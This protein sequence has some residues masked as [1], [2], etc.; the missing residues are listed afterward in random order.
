MSATV[1][2]PTAPQLGPPDTT[3][4]PR[5]TGLVR[6]ATGVPPLAAS[7]RCDAR[8]HGGVA[9]PRTAPVREDRAQVPREPA[10]LGLRQRGGRAHSRRP[11]AFYR[12]PA[13]AGWAAGSPPP[14]S[15][16]SIPPISR[17]PS[18]PGRRPH[19][20]PRPR[21]CA[22]PC[23]RL[24]SP[25]PCAW[26]AADL[27]I[28]AA[29][30]GRP[31]GRPSG[32]SSD[33][34]ARGAGRLPLV[35]ESPPGV[36]GPSGGGPHLGGVRPGGLER[37]DRPGAVLGV[38]RRVHVPEFRPRRRCRTSGGARRPWTRRSPRPASRRQ[39]VRPVR[40][41]APRTRAPRR[42]PP[43]RRRPAGA[44][45]PPRRPRHRPRRPSPHRR[46]VRRAP[47]GARLPSSSARFRATMS[48]ASPWPSASRPSATERRIPGSASSN[49]R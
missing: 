18:M 25:G 12:G 39:P 16:P 32:G 48:A 22:C 42:W 13:P 34:P 38:E 3:A 35:E 29:P 7:P 14:P 6:R 47:G 36:G 11:R 37:V 49:W 26:P 2:T 40:P 28:P 17:W 15:P 31:D 43:V 46:S 30:P 23:R 10:V 5:R 20:P 41:R 24:S 8:G 1:T 19:S 44:H 33:R 27:R 4:P 21:G 45:R 9:L